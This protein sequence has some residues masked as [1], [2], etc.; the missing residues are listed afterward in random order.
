M[1]PPWRA[2]AGRARRGPYSF[3][4]FVAPRQSHLHD[5]CPPVRDPPLI[6]IAA[7]ETSERIPSFTVWHGIARQKRSSVQSRP[8][9][10]E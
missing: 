4:L 9:A 6:L 10:L 2:L 3:D 5:R 7:I 1:P 8:L